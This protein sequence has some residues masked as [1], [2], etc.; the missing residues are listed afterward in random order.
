V[1]SPPPTRFPH[2]RTEPTPLSSPYSVGPTEENKTISDRRAPAAPAK[3]SGPRVTG[4]GQRKV[5]GAGPCSSLSSCLSRK[6]RLILEVGPAT[7][8]RTARPFSF[9]PLAFAA[10]WRTTAH[11]APRPRLL[12]LNGRFSRMTRR[13]LSRGRGGKPGLPLCYCLTSLPRTVHRLSGGPESPADAKF[14]P[15]TY[16]KCTY[17]LLLPA[18]LAFIYHYNYGPNIV[19]M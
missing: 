19:P 4:D 3:P 5:R 1:W 16:K 13:G 9:P 12:R 7:S 8:A 17:W 6:K 15:S 10:L 2:P 11:G 14:D 18:W